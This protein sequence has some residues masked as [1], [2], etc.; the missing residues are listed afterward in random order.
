MRVFPFVVIIPYGH[1]D[2]TLCRSAYQ[3]K[4]TEV[5]P[6]R[7]SFRKLS[8]VLFDVVKEIPNETILNGDLLCALTALAACFADGDAVDEFHCIKIEDEAQS[9]PWSYEDMT[10]AIDDSGI[11]GF[12]WSSPYQFTEVVTENSNLLPF[13]DITDVFDT[14]S[15]VVNAWDGLAQGS[16]ALRGIEI[17]VDEIRL[18]LTRVTE[19]D[20]RDSGLLIPVWDF[21]GTMTYLYESNGQ[22]QKMDVGPIPILTVNAIDGSVINRNLGY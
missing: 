10:F 18:G 1:Y 20:K 8:D 13:Q 5:L 11:V 22:T 2:K 15:L 6:S 19:Q 17:N 16:P 7:A 14:M 4:T 21:F 12:R 3:S 9:A